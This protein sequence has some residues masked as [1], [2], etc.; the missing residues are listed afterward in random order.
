MNELIKVSTN[1]Q[2][3]KVVSARELHEFLIKDAKGGQK[4]QQFNHWIKDKL[5]HL[6]AEINEE[7]FI[8]NYDV[9]GNNIPISESSQSDNQEVRIHKT[10][11]ILK[12]DLAKQMAMVQN[13]D[14]GKQARRYFIECEK[15]LKETAKPLSTLDYLEYS[16]KQMR[17]QETRIS[18]V[19]N[20][21]LEIEAKAT[22]RPEYFTVMGYAILNGVKVGLSLA[23]QI[24]RKAKAICNNKGYHIDKIHDPRFGQVGC[25]PAD[26]LKEAFNT[27][28]I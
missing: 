8:I 19:E 12:I 6:D 13:N 24:G 3:E 20:K 7:Y 4:G 15:V 17:E 18:T 25:Y 5:E 16:L 9:Y 21:L 14:K 23:A 11:Y 2:G 1:S 10:D 22:T 26:V 27:I 28:S